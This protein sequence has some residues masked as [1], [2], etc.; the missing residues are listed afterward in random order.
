MQDNFRKFEEIVFC[1]LWFPDSGFRIPDS[2]FRIPDSGFRFRILVSDSGFRFPGF[3]VALL[4]V[5]VSLVLTFDASIIMS[6]SASEEGQYIS[7]SIL[8]TLT[9]ML[10]FSKN[11]VD[12]M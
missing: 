6:I 12:I 4:H 1:N 11:I 7:I 3:R 2:G 8:L 10:T 9:L 5:P